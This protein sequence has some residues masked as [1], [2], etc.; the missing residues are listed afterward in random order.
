[1][2]VNDQSDKRQRWTNL[3]HFHITYA[4][5]TSTKQAELNEKFGEIP[6]DTPTRQLEHSDPNNETAATYLQHN[7]F[8]KDPSCE[9]LAT[10]T[11]MTCDLC[12]TLIEKRLVERYL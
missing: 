7:Q 9:F 11:P 6:D 8:S 12:F 10:K 4:A 3:A 5:W 2:H 1:M